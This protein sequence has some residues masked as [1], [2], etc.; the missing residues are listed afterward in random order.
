MIKH[1]LH[2]ML[3]YRSIPIIDVLD[4]LMNKENLKFDIVKDEDNI[5]ASFDIIVDKLQVYR[6]KAALN[7]INF[8]EAPFSIN[9]FNNAMIPL[10]VKNNDDLEIF[11]RLE[12][13][14]NYGI[15]NA[16]IMIC[17]Y[18]CEDK[19]RMN[20]YNNLVKYI[21]NDCVFATE[22]RLDFQRMRNLILKGPPIY[23]NYIVK[24]RKKLG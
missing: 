1:Y 14:I 22:L 9:N 11:G 7:N 24:Q 17:R 15:K 10:Y 13:N 8:K 19:E 12:I 4:N 23:L 16:R 18:Y 21:L 20:Y 2:K 5:A 6:V 3:F